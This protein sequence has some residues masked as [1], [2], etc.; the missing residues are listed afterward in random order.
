MSDVTRGS[1]PDLVPIEC[2]RYEKG[3]AL[4]AAYSPRLKRIGIQN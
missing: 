2:K 1:I 4:V 3:T